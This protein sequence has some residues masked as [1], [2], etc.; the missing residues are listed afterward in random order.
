[1]N[2]RRFFP[3]RDGTARVVRGPWRAAVLLALIGAVAP[4]AGASGATARAPAA[5]A[6]KSAAPPAADGR[7]VMERMTRAFYYPG[8]DM[9]ATIVMELSDSVGVVR[10]RV[11]SM[12]RLNLPDG[13]DQK[14]LVYFLHPGDVRRMSCMVWKH[15]GADDDR[16]IYVPATSSIRRIR[17]PERSAFL[18]SDFVREEFS[19]R[20]VEAD[21]HAL[22]RVERTGGRDCY[23]VESLPREPRE[24]SRFTTWIDRSTYLPIRQEFR[25]ARG[26]VT[27][28]FTAD[29]I[30][31]VSDGEAPGGKVPT[32]VERTMRNAIS[33]HWTRVVCDSVRYDVGLKE[34]DFSDAHMKIP[35]SAWLP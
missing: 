12:L 13:R 17:A 7:E 4:A 19:G 35:L 32:V 29:R 8:R 33:G 14:Y 9:R 2:P 22:Q 26:E 34:R 23:V 30:E 21:T 31:E 15:A 11:M 24:Y 10:K 18:G 20:D 16:W 5:P 3:G 25:N 27:R 6:A 1:M 28:I